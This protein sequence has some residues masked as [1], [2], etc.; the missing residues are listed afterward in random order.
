SKNGLLVDF[1]DVEKMADMAREVLDRPGE[2]KPLGQAGVEMI[3][4]RYSLDVCLPR[5]L[6]LYED[7]VHARHERRQFQWTARARP[8]NNRDRRESA[9][10]P[11][12]FALPST[13]GAAPRRA[14]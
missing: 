4:E 2:H 8:P 11:I 9:I 7:A 1:F 14:A 3:R 10:T 6:A 5:M 12:V 13:H